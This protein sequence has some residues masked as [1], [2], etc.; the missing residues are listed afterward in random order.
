MNAKTL[1]LSY[2]NNKEWAIHFLLW[3][4]MISERWINHAPLKDHFWIYGFIKL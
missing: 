1:K 2:T 3:F 4:F